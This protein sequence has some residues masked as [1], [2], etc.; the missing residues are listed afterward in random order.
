MN[1]TG[2]DGTRDAGASRLPRARRG[3]TGL[4]S[5][6]LTLVVLTFEARSSRLS[7]G[8]SAASCSGVRRNATALRLLTWALAATSGA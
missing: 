2:D 3:L 5:V 4:A 7:T 8:L 6:V 1:G